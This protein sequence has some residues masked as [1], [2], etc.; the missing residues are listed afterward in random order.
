MNNERID[1]LLKVIEGLIDTVERQDGEIKQL[2]NAL[3]STGE[4]VDNHNEG[5]NLILQVLN[6]NGLI[7]VDI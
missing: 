7:D 6:A 4:L 2:Q 5:I 3:V 1:S